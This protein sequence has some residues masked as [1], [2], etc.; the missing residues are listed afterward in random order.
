[1]TYLLRNKEFATKRASKYHI[2][3]DEAQEMTLVRMKTALSS[4][5]FL[6]FPDWNYPFTLKTDAS[7]VGA[8]TILDRVMGEET[9]H[10]PS[11]VTGFPR[12]TLRRD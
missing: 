8:G 10:I 5:T 12:V 1:M 3:L 6:A 7:E 9:F 4:P 11:Q 2:E